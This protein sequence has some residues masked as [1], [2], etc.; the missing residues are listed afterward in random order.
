MAMID[1]Y[2]GI[3]PAPS[4]SPATR[5]ASA[6]GVSVDLRGYHAATVIVQTGTITDGTHDISIKESDDNS[7]FTAVATG[8]L[9]GSLP[10][11]TAPDDDKTYKVGYMGRKRYLRVDVTV[12][13]ATSG[14]IVGASVIRSRARKQPK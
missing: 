5:T 7:T 4:L 10:S 8:D 9:I 1:S 6:N 14:G 2:N 3:S 11:I 13:G 12:S